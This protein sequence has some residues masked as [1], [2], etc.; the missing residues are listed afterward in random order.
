MTFKV[1][2]SNATLSSKWNEVHFPYLCYL[3][4][5]GQEQSHTESLSKVSK[6]LKPVVHNILLVIE[7][8]IF[9]TTE[10]I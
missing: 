7:Y 3:G 4:A 5:W 9:L 6:G 1:C 10:R 2:L 8:H